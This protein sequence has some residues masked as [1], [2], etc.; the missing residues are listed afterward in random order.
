MLPCCW[1]YFIKSKHS[2]WDTLYYICVKPFMT[3]IKILAQF[4]LDS[5]ETLPKAPYIH[6]ELVCLCSIVGSMAVGSGY[7]ILPKDPTQAEVRWVRLNH[8]LVTSN[9]RGCDKPFEFHHT[10]RS[11]AY[12]NTEFLSVYLFG[13]LQQ[14]ET[15]ERW[16][17]S[18][19]NIIRTERQIW[20]KWVKWI[21]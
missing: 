3:L 2:F 15:K 4:R 8:S 12:V 7:T 14:A 5:I 21:L 18:K 16:I 19:N 20:L 9:M 1:K 10:T 11:V 6:V 13:T 17:L